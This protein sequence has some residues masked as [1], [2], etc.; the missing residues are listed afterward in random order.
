MRPWQ[1]PAHRLPVTVRPAGVRA[2]VVDPIRDRLAGLAVEE[3]VRVDPDGLAFGRPLP[4]G[5]LVLADQ[6][7]G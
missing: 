6:L 5:V 2:G 3:V 1:R 4:A 7:P